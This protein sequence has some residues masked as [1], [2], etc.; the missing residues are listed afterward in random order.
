MQSLSLGIS[1]RVFF[2][3]INLSELYCLMNE[4]REFLKT[5]TEYIIGTSL[6]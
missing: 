6:S 4:Y 1:L 5:I 3:N 2:S